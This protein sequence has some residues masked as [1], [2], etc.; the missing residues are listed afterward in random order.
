MGVKLAACQPCLAACFIAVAAMGCELLLS[1]PHFNR[2]AGEDP[3][4]VVAEDG[5]PEGDPSEDGTP[6]VPQEPTDM[7]AEGDVE[8]PAEDLPGEDPA[9]DDGEIPS[10]GCDGLVLL[11]HFD[12]RED[13]G[14]AVTRVR[15]FSGAG[16][17]GTVTG[18]AFDASA[19]KF[20]GAY[21]FDGEG[22]IIIVNDDDTLDLTGALT[23]AAWVFP[24]NSTG[25][26]YILSKASADGTDPYL[27]YGI[28]FSGDSLRLRFVVSSMTQYQIE[29]DVLELGRW[30]H[31]VGTF[32]LDGPVPSMRFFIDGVFVGGEGVTE[33]IVTN[34]KNLI[35]GGWEYDTSESWIGVID[36]LAVFNRA[37]GADEVRALYLM[38]TPIPCDVL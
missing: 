19:G 33:P 27:Q 22:D 32:D 21:R 4:D 3:G 20:D 25:F 14:E 35:V 11:M 30:V 10:L 38:A 9:E 8:E 34:A 26:N 18:A 37:L 36:E 5:T 15:D 29:S 1:R 28:G 12:K 2:D 6:D 7:D 31:V 17:D 24:E 23:V 16:N 13:L